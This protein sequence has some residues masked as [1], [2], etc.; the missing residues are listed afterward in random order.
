[1][2]E[3]Q[4]LSLVGKIPWRRAWLP[5]PVILPGQSHGQRNL[6]GYSPQGHKELEITERLSTQNVNLNTLLGSSV[7][8]K[9]LPRMTRASVRMSVRLRFCWD[10]VDS[11]LSLC[12]GLFLSSS[13]CLNSFHIKKNLAAVLASEISLTSSLTF[14][15]VHQTTS[16]RW[17]LCKYQAV[18]ACMQAKSLQSCLTL[19][20]PMDYNLPGSSM[21]FSR[22]EYWSR[23]P[24]SSPGYLPNS[25]IELQS[26]VSPALTGMFFTTNATWE[27]R[28]QANPG[29]NPS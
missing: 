26:L 27:A 29:S 12:S 20:H 10:S 1:M 9:H 23:L 28:Y 6:A 11:P 15:Q 22:Q 3:T 5:I 4:V 24:C 7:Y 19:C 2:Q 13:C 14:S 17:W 18:S 16:P 21:G 25:G 8:A